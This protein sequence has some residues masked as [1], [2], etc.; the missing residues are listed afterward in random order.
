ME[1]KLTARPRITVGLKRLCFPSIGKPRRN[2]QPACPLLRWCKFHDSMSEPSW[3]VSL[4]AEGVGKEF[5]A[6]HVDLGD[7]PKCPGYSVFSR[8]SQIFSN[9]ACLLAYSHAIAV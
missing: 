1:N 6:K 3:I 4:L 7:E 9:S 8:N 2:I 5:P